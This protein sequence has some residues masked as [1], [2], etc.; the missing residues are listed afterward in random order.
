M[1]SSPSELVLEQSCVG[2]FCSSK[3]L[4]RTQILGAGMMLLSMTWNVIN[5]LAVIADLERHGGVQFSKNSL[6]IHLAWLSEAEG[7][8]K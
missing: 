5:P 8:I 7:M 3:H 1:L 2:M 6:K 4:A